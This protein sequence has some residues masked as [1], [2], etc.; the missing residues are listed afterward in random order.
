ME[1]SADAT[2]A[3]WGL[4]V[5]RGRIEAWQRGT[6]AQCEDERQEVITIQKTLNAVLAE[7]DALMIAASCGTDR[8]VSESL[9]VQCIADAWAGE[10]KPLL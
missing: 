8:L 7:I 10:N 3:K 1:R 5:L 9:A 6:T 2:K 4:D